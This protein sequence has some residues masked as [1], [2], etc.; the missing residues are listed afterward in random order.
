MLLCNQL[1][2]LQ[3]EPLSH[4]VGAPGRGQGV[5]RGRGGG[6]TLR[7]AGAAPPSRR[8]LPSPAPSHCLRT[9]SGFAAPSPSRHQRSSGVRAAPRG[10]TV[11]LLVCQSVCLS[12]ASVRRTP[13]L[14]APSPTRENPRGW[15]GAEQGDRLP[16]TGCPRSP[17]PPSLQLRVFSEAQG[18]RPH[19]HPAPNPHTAA[20]LPHPPP[21]AKA[22]PTTGRPS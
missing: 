11:G 8:G 19:A 7:L 17:R 3:S 22:R 15:R 14:P 18:L 13:L 5:G 21:P 4:S 12:S 20:M 16:P 10:R 6:F 9:T 2:E 1:A